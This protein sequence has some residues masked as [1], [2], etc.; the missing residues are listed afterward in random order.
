M[1]ESRRGQKPPSRASVSPFSPSRDDISSSAGIFAP[2]GS[3]SGLSAVSTGPKTSLPFTLQPRTT[4]PPPPRAADGCSTSGCASDGLSPSLP[5]ADRPRCF[6]RLRLPTQSPEASLLSVSRSL[7]P[8]D[9]A[10]RHSPFAGFPPLRA[11]GLRGRRGPLRHSERLRA[12]R[13]VYILYYQDLR[14]RGPC[15]RDTRAVT[16]HV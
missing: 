15:K 12:R 16:L 14:A 6:H 1:S 8:R 9:V 7:P 13:R 4:L 2:L 10:F 5:G 3:L 11:E